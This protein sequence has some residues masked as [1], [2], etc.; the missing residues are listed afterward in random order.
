LLRLKLTK[1]LK[2]RGIF[3]QID[4]WQIHFMNAN[5]DEVLNRENSIT[6]L[7]Q[8]MSNPTGIL[9]QD[10][11]S[12]V[13]TF[14]H[15][16]TKYVIKK[17][18]LQNTW[19]WFRWT[20]VLFESL[21]EIA[22]RN[23]ILLQEDG[24]II[25]E[26]IMLFQRVRN[27]TIS[28][29]WMIYKYM[30]G[31]ELLSTDV[32][33]IVSFVKSMHKQGWVH[34]DAH[35]ANFLRTAN[36]IATLDPIRATRSRNMYLRAC[37]VLHMMRDMPKAGE[38]YDDDKLGVWLKISLFSHNLGKIFR[39]IKQKARAIFGNSTHKTDANSMSHNPVN[40]E[41]VRKND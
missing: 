20:S 19:F 34:R 16:K 7:M 33:D 15:D 40:T 17:F 36:G 10:H 4:G 5:T 18:T 13:A 11:R 14:E 25:P 29:S 23:S 22:Y 24:L 12:Y 39:L 27:L 30:D 28:H 6:D 31:E 37:D 2:N 1:F 41:S 9:K 32:I 8:Q 38:L 35:P 3:T 21:G 26:P